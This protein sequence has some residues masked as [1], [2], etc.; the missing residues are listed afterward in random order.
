MARQLSCVSNDLC[1]IRLL[2]KEED[3]RQYMCGRCHNLAINTKAL[4]CT[5]NHEQDIAL[6][7]GPCATSI[8][9]DDQCPIN[10][11]QNPIFADQRVVQARIQRDIEFICPYSAQF[12]RHH[13]PIRGAIQDTIEGKQEQGQATGCRWK[14]T[15]AQ[16]HHHVTNCQ[17]K[18]RESK[19]LI[20]L[21]RKVQTLEGDNA[22]L[23]NKMRAMERIMQGLRQS[24][25]VL[26]N[27]L[28]NKV[29]RDEMKEFIP[30]Q[31]P[32]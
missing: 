5:D 16:L 28:S 13:S 12:N 31:P 8:Q 2:Y 27:E 26:T 11:H 24:M 19:S 6:Y 3:K 9:S 1:D 10:Q 17:F 29:N 22:G 4:I 15:Y 21:K 18:P 32:Q 25:D 14:G 20:D 23:N 7:C 30:P